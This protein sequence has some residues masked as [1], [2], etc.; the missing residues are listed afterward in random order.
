MSGLHL[1][2]KGCFLSEKKIKLDIVFFFGTME[3]CQKNLGEEYV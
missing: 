3:L 1:T 2:Y